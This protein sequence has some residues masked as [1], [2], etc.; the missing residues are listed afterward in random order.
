LLTI[1]TFENVH[2]WVHQGIPFTSKPYS[3]EGHFKY[4]SVDSD[5]AIIYAKLSKYNYQLNKQDTI[6]EAKF[7][8]KKT[9]PNYQLF[10][11][12]FNYINPN[13]SPDTLC[14]VFVSSGGGQN[15]EGKAGSTL[16]IDD[17]KF[18]YNKS[19]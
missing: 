16:F 11:S 12:K 4:F 6:A 7:I 13:I 10:N 15:F 19:R 2:P 14:I 3:F 18:I 5:S 1:G 9:V 17:I 8:I